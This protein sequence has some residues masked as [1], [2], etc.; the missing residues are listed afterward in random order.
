MRKQMEI[1]FIA[2]AGNLEHC[3]LDKNPFN[4]EVSLKITYDDFRLSVLKRKSVLDGTEED[5]YEQ[6][7][8]VTNE[9]SGTKEEPFQKFWNVEFNF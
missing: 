9:K 2:L 3:L 5:N 8:D 1:F 4:Y 6:K 7:E